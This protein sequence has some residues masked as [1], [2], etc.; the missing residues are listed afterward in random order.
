[1]KLNEINTHIDQC[2][3]ENFIVHIYVYI[4]A[5]GSL[6][7][8]LTYSELANISINRAKL[9]EMFPNKRTCTQDFYV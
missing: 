7:F 2:E 5:I 6:N 8:G 3:K 4:A 1:M 9:R